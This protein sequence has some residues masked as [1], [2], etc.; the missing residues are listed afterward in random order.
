MKNYISINISY[1][2]AKTGLKQKDFGNLFG[3]SGSV[4]SS[5][6]SGTIPPIEFIQ[7]LCSHFKIPIDDFINKELSSIPVNPV[8][9]VKEQFLQYEKNIQAYEDLIKAKDELIS[10]KQALINEL[11]EQINKLDKLVEIQNVL[12]NQ[13]NILPSK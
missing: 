4:I 7:K 9:D 6:N 12:L 11:R 8:I 1:L 2:R 10:E 5:Y 3:V 13:N